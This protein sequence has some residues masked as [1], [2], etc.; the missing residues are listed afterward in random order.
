MYVEDKKK[1][2]SY[3][4]LLKIDRVS[5]TGVKLSVIREV[6]FASLTPLPESEAS[7]PKLRFPPVDSKKKQKVGIKLMIC[8]IERCNGGLL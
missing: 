5:T 4:Q 7:Q 6:S 8:F 1:L 2:Y 3:I